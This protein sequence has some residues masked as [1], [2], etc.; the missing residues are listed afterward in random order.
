M[1]FIV[2]LV[3]LYLAFLALK[4]KGHLVFYSN[5]SRNKN[6]HDRNAAKEEGEVTIDSSNASKNS[7]SGS[8]GEYVDYEDVK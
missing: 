6:D 7:G 3:L 1:K 4:K 8:Q 5:M 2:I